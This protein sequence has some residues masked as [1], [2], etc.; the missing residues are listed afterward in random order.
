MDVLFVVIFAIAFVILMKVIYVRA[1]FKQ[2]INKRPKF[3]WLPKYIVPFETTT[4]ELLK[5]L[6]QNGFEPVDGS[7]QLFKRGKVLG[8]FSAKHLLLHVE[9]L[10]NQNAFKL[11][12]GSLAIFDTGDLWRASSEILKAS[13]P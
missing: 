4:E 11:F 12:A 8:D 3:V 2:W 10:E 5:S 9:I 13:N 1:S 7:S 6:E